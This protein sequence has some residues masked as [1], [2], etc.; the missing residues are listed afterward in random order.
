MK[1][2]FSDNHT[3]E[4]SNTIYEERRQ[5]AVRNFASYGHLGVTA[6]DHWAIGGSPDIELNRNQGK[7]LGELWS[8][9]K[10]KDRLD[11]QVDFLDQ[12]R[13]RYV[14]EP[15]GPDGQW[16]KDDII[17]VKKSLRSALHY[18]DLINKL[19]EEYK[20]FQV[21]DLEVDPK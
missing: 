2:K 8:I 17:S 14:M 12:A 5:Q 9:E 13:R 21:E 16:A 3:E 18:L 7:T 10:I 6:A 4:V 11:S 19:P 15:S 1:N 20:R